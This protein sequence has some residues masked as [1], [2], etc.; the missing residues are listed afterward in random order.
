MLTGKAEQGKIAWQVLGCL[1]FLPADIQRAYPSVEQK[2]TFVAW[3]GLGGG[4]EERRNDPSTA[5]LPLES[6]AEKELAAVIFV[7]KKRWSLVE[8]AR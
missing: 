2:V 8:R 3:R 1:I 6:A 5:S 7:S 4:C